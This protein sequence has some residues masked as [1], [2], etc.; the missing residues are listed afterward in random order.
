MRS[1]E[2][3]MNEGPKSRKQDGRGGTKRRNLSSFVPQIE[4]PLFCAFVR[5]TAPGGVRKLVRQ[6]DALS[7]AQSNFPSADFAL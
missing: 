2:K 3:E 7:S 6:K 1:M 4:F 5:T